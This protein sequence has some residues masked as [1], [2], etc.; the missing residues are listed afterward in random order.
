MIERGNSRIESL[1]LDVLHLLFTCL[2]GTDRL[3]FA[4][5]SPLLWST[6][7][8][9]KPY[10]PI[11]WTLITPST[12]TGDFSKTQYDL[13]ENY[14]S[15]SKT[16]KPL[17]CLLQQWMKPKYRMIRFSKEQGKNRSDFK[18]IIKSQLPPFFVKTG[19]KDS[20]YWFHQDESR[21][22]RRYA[23]YHACR[24]DA[25]EETAPVTDV[26]SSDTRKSS[27]GRKYLLP[28]PR[29][30]SAYKWYYAV[31]KTIEEDKDRWRTWDEWEQWWLNYQWWGLE[32]RAKDYAEEL[33]RDGLGI[34]DPNQNLG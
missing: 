23:I 29:G 2:N 7:I 8:T 5:A 22:I 19:W 12:T 26:S 15:I 9:T 24:R 3:L 33:V 6:Y 20:K 13:P 10:I 4:L 17:G 32:R 27:S 28:H 16:E 30:L 21:L 25:S 34:P 18:Y 1:P 31:K 14:P 11:L